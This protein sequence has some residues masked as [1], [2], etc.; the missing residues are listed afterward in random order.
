VPREFCKD[1]PPKCLAKAIEDPANGCLQDMWNNQFCDPQCNV[2]ECDHNDCTPGQIASKCVDRTII[3]GIDLSVPPGV[4]AALAQHGSHRRMSEVK[5]SNKSAT[6]TAVALQLQFDPAFLMI[7]ED[8]NAMVNTQAFYYE[9]QWEDPRLVGTPCQQVVDSLLSLSREESVSDKARDDKRLYKKI[10]WRPSLTVIDALDPAVFEDYIDI[11][12]TPDSI[13]WRAGTA[14]LPD[15]SVAKDCKSCMLMKAEVEWEIEYEFLYHSFPFD[16]QL[17]TVDIQVEGTNLFTCEGEGLSVLAEMGLDDMSPEESGKALV[18]G[19][20]VWVIDGPYNEAV[21][22]YHPLD[23]AGNKQVDKCRVEIKIVRNPLE[24][25]VKI[26]C[27]TVFVI[28]FGGFTSLWMHPVDLL[29][30]RIASL[31]TALLIVV[32]NMQT[33]PGLGL[34]NYLTWNDYFNVAQILLL[35][36]A[37]GQTLLVHVLL[38]KK[39]TVIAALF[40]RIFRMCLPFGVYIFMTPGF[41]MWAIN[42][43]GDGARYGLICGGGGTF[44]VLVYGFFKI[45]RDLKN[46]IKDMVKTVNALHAANADDEDYE[47]LIWDLFSVFDADDSGDINMREARRL[48]Q[49]LYPQLQRDQMMLVMQE[50]RNYVDGN[51]CLERDDF[52]DAMEGLR[53]FIDEQDWGIRAIG[54]APRKDDGEEEGA[55]KKQTRKQKNAAFIGKIF[56]FFSPQ[57]G[58]TTAQRIDKVPKDHIL[59]K[60]KPQ[61]EEEEPEEVKTEAAAPGASADEIAKAM[62]QVMKPLMV[63]LQNLNMKLDVLGQEHQEAQAPGASRHVMARLEAVAEK[64]DKVVDPQVPPSAAPLPAEIDIT[65]E[66][67]ARLPARAHHLS[68]RLLTHLSA[69]QPSK[70]A[71][72][73]HAPKGPKGGA[74]AANGAAMLAS[75]ELTTDL[76]AS[77]VQGASAAVAARQRAAALRGA[78]PPKVPHPTGREER[79]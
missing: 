26:L 68:N 78:A 32:V 43:Y 77:A 75:T 13:P 47:D 19:A 76:P 33:D 30:D 67:L 71:N 60:P 34:V 36:L 59:N 73:A 23:E 10:F 5:A 48:M 56:A 51:N 6:A 11:T 17:V 12:Y 37:V 57:S 63:T 69:A 61:E 54:S 25:I 44:L 24:F 58:E 20:T 50:L 3:E 21:S 16:R 49:A 1:C 52:V 46:T 74:L 55:T 65:L 42:L 18:N 9:L 45:G 28:L 4:A 35:M 41:F 70:P 31:M 27:I 29:G 62:G 72:G 53:N 66:E 7:N 39:H 79:L 22:A 2:L 40:D 38:N 64:L 15:G 14:T 8:I